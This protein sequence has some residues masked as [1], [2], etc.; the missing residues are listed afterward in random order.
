MM[1]V[2]AGDSVGVGST[3]VASRCSITCPP[4]KRL[5]AG[6][7]TAAPMCRWSVIR[8][9]YQARS[10]LG[11]ED[12]RQD[13]SERNSD[14]VHLGTSSGG[15]TCPAY[16]IDSPAG[17]DGLMAFIAAPDVTFLQS[18]CSLSQCGES[19]RRCDRRR[20]ACSFQSV[21]EGTGRAAE[22]GTAA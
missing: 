5:F 14:N 4:F 8:S 20:S 9:S 7:I 11:P 16:D 3:G 21:E 1:L 10:G 6:V 2:S 22:E 13:Y 18:S 15:N 17:D 19:R 12:N